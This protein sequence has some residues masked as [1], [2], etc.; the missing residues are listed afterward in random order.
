MTEFESRWRD[1][2]LTKLDA[3]LDCFKC[4]DERIRDEAMC[5]YCGNVLD[6]ATALF[7]SMNGK[8]PATSEQIATEA[9]LNERY[10]REWL[11]W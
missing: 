1:F 10:V 6:Q 2:A 11:A 3:A 4:S 5:C 9:E 7:V 8:P